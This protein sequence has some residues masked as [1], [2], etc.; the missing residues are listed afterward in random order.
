MPNHPDTETKQCQPKKKKKTKEW[1][2]QNISN[3][4]VP[5]SQHSLNSCHKNSD[6]DSLTG[7]IYNKELGT[8]LVKIAE[9][10]LNTELGFSRQDMITIYRC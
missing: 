1:H 6:W 2:H 9:D 4:S 3:L 10:W 8:K 5:K 7:T